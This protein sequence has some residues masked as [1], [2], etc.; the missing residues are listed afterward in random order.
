VK[1]E[2]KFYDRTTTQGCS[3]SC[4]EG[5]VSLARLSLTP[6]ESLASKTTERGKDG[7]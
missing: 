7:K 2:V 1:I 5:V 3:D 6:R 4:A